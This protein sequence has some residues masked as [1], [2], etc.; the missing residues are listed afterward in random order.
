MGKCFKIA[1]V[2][3]FVMFFFAA[4]VQAAGLVGKPAP[5][6]NAKEW[7]NTEKPLSLHKLKG[8]IVFIEFTATW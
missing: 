8:K 2:V 3:L 7:L 4:M 6:I 5:P 1:V